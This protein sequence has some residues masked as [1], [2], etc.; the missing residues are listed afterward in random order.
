MPGVLHGAAVPRSPG[1]KPGVVL[2]SV[3][4]SSRKAR[5]GDLQ[6]PKRIS[7]EKPAFAKGELR[8]T[9]VERAGQLRQRASES[10]WLNQSVSR[11]ASK[12]KGT[13]RAERPPRVASRRRRPVPPG[14]TWKSVDH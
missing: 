13:P 4:D 12:G 1:G 6:I 11:G 8:P 7:P 10:N 14:G 9:C 3:S 5:F 2:D